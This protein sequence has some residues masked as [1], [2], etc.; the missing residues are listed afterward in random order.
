MTPLPT[1]LERR[2]E[3]ADR[4]LAEAEALRRAAMDDVWRGAN[5]VLAG[6]AASALRSARRLVHRLQRRRALSRGQV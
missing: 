4:A 3:L 2:R 6:A 1:E 5:A